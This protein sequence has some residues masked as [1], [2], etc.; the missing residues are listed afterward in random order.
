MNPPYDCNIKS[1]SHQQLPDPARARPPRREQT[2]STHPSPYPY[3][4]RV[5]VRLLGPDSAGGVSTRTHNAGAKFITPACPRARRPHTICHERPHIPELDACLDESRP[6]RAS[7]HPARHINR[8][9]ARAHVHPSPLAPRRATP[10]SQPPNRPANHPPPEPHPRIRAQG[11]RRMKGKA[12]QAE[13][14]QS[15]SG[16]ARRAHQPKPAPWAWDARS[17]RVPEPR[18]AP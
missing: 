11:H 5:H 13:R 7:Q 9:S 12:C 2:D 17:T 14:T 1:S 4:L 6:P 3:P 15:L 18:P 10:A 8:T 16:P